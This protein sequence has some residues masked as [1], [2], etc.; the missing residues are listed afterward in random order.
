MNSDKLDYLLDYWFTAKIV[1]TARWKMHKIKY[2]ERL[3]S[4]LASPGSLLSLNLHVSPVPKD[5]NL[6][7]WFCME[8][9]L[10]GHDGS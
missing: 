6:F 7:F 1:G 9:S 10:H 2:G 4:F 3:R 8:A 5:L